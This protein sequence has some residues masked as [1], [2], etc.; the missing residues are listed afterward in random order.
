MTAAASAAALA[1]SPAA[2]ATVLDV[3][4]SS[5]C[6]QS[7]C[8]NDNGVFTQTW[9]AAGASGPMTIGQF[10]MDRGI[11]GD[12]DGE[13]FSISFSV[14]GQEL[15]SWGSYVMAGIGGEELNFDGLDF[16]WNPEDGDLVLTLT[17]K[18][19]PNMGAGGGG[20]FFS[21]S[22]SEDGEDGGGLG[23]LGGP[24]QGGGLEPQGGPDQGPAAVPEPATWALMI[25]GF[26]LAGASLRQ[27]RRFTA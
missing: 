8:F 3:N 1:A 23:P 12:L 17:L 21:S 9:S 24:D 5:G 15:G 11:L 16:V 4:W 10:L 18:P 6:G 14:G 27:R 25:A 22:P 13:T 26:G 2:A 20:G 19:P 7:N